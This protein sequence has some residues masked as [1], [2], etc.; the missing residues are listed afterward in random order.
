MVVGWCE[1][2]ESA[3]RGDDYCRDARNAKRGTRLRVPLWCGV[4]LAAVA[5]R[6]GGRADDCFLLDVVEPGVVV[7]VRVGGCGQ[8]EQC[9]G[10]SGCDSG[11]D[12]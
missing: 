10:E 5:Y 4:V 12:C 2:R 6:G 1:G 11:G 9:G 8:A 3:T 7:D